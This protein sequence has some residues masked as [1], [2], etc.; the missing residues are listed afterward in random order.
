MPVLFAIHLLKMWN[1][2]SYTAQVLLLSCVKS[3]LPPLHNYLD[4]DGI[5]L[6]IRKK[7]IGY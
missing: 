2:I 6:Q 5:V 3:C 4:I 7:S 1:I